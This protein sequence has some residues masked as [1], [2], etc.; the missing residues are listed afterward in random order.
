M[1][2]EALVGS[3]HERIGGGGGS[4]G[5]DRGRTEGGTVDTTKAS[6]R[7]ALPSR[8]RGRGRARRFSVVDDIMD[9]CGRVVN[10]HFLGPL[11]A[12]KCYYHHHKRRE[13]KHTP[14]S[15]SYAYS[16]STSTP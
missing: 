6:G 4:C 10:I 11:L 15:S 7:A 5:G 16:S 12:H 1:E 8:S 9:R 14:L 13:K 2:S 3:V